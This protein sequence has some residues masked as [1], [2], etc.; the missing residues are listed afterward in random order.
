MRSINTKTSDEKLIDLFKSGNDYAFT[1]LLKKHK[2]RALSL[3]K[4]Q[5]GEKQSID[6]HFQEAT[7]KI[8]KHIKN[9]KYIEKGKFLPLLIRITINSIIDDYRKENKGYKPKIIQERN[10]NYVYEQ[11]PY[12]DDYLDVIEKEQLII[13][14]LNLTKELSNEQRKVI[15]LHYVHGV[16][17]KDIAKKMNLSINTVLSISRYGLINLKKIWKKNH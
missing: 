4:L 14:V 11:T 2:T 7:I 12:N 6:D 9:G 10:L 1:I 3:I 8:S 15:L 16:K 5:V 17:F 13:D